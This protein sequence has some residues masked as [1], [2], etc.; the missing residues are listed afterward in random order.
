MKI[1]KFFLFILLAVPVCSA[2]QENPAP[3]VPENRK[4]LIK[5]AWRVASRISDD[6]QKIHLAFDSSFL[7]HIPPEKLSDL[8]K[9]IYR[10]NGKVTEVS[11]SGLEGENSGHF[12][13]RT[14][15]DYMLPVSITVEKG[16][17]KIIGLFFRPSYQKL[18]AVED[19]KDKLNKLPGKKGLLIL[20]LND[21]INLLDSLNPD[22]N[23][24]I[25]SAFKLYVLAAML[26]EDVSWKK[27]IQLKEAGKSLPSG[28]LQ[29]WP[30]DAPLALH[31]LATLMISES[32]NTASDLLIDYLGREF[33]EKNLKKFGHSNPAALSP[34]LKT[35]DMFRLKSSS[36]T[37]GR[38]IKSS[39]EE[40]RVLLEKEIPKMPL[41]VSAVP[42][43]PFEINRIEWFASP[44]D[45]CKLMDYFYRQND[46]TAFG[47]MA[48]NPGLAIPKDRF[49]YAGY[50][51]GS[52]A[53]VLNMTWLLKI[54]KSDWYC[55]TAS[56]NNEKEPLEEN[57][58]F[59]IMQ[60]AINLIAQ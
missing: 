14:D 1:L 15:K 43:E 10:S 51:G 48:I 19:I 52:E 2:G 12:I 53:G 56:W 55:L 30:E 25:G 58:F 13:F 24:A 11:L 36:E 29:N 38:Y 49:G 3:A 59:E 41:S 18:T 47:I 33:I 7:K 57:K 37:A 35:S 26:E 9:N 21:P 39:I 54:K 28:R 6:P 22:Q 17:G 34:F 40:K 44:S 4:L 45:M 16:R 31:T 46:G 42:A 50:K 27:T 8:L 60:S 20:K 32:D 5:A 23:F